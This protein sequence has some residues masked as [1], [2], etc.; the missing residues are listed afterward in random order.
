MFHVLSCGSAR[1]HRGNPA[2]ALAV[3]RLYSGPTL[4]SGL[5]SLVLSSSE[6]RSVS[7]HQKNCL[8]KLQRLLPRTPTCAVMLL[9][10]SLPAE[11]L[12]AMRKIS[13]LGM[14]AR[15]GPNNLLFKQAIF[16]LTNGINSSWFHDAR[17]LAKLYSLPDPIV[18]LNDP[19]SKFSWKKIIKNQVSSHWHQ[20]YCDEVS[21]RSS[22]CFLRPAFL[23]LNGKPHPLWSSCQSS[24]TAVRAA[25]IQAR[26][27]TGRYHTDLLRS[28]WDGNDRT[29]RLPGCGTPEADSVHLL[30]GQ[31]EALKSYLDASLQHNLQS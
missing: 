11:A 2:A 26:I 5:A 22:L 13:L 18:I 30:S 1:G 4:Y 12:L 3:E 24:P 16:S 17:L 21:H 7:L 29:C 20:R 15:L 10:S 27:L 8:L 14:I 28:K 31:C 9:A 25:T 23:P 6:L 19:P